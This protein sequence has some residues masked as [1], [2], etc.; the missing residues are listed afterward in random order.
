MGRGP[1][2]LAFLLSLVT[3]GPVFA[4]SITLE[5]DA[6]SGTISGYAVYVGSAQRIDVGNT[7]TFTLTTAAA[8]QQYCFAVA[9]YNS[10]G[11]GPKSG[12]VCGYSNQ[13]PALTN[14]GN[15]SATVGQSASLQLTGSDP[16]GHAITYSAAGLPP[17]LFIGTATGFVS[18]TP[19]AAGSYSVTARVHDGMLQSSAQTFTWSVANAP[20][21][22]TSSPLVTISGPTSSPTYTSSTATMSLNGSSSD[23]V[24]VTSVS[25]VNDRGGSGTASGTTSW[26]IASVGLQVGTNVITVTARDAAGNVG[27]DVLTVTHSLPDTTAPSVAISSPTAA[28]THASASST[29]TISGAAAD[30]VGVTQVSWANDRGGSGTAAGTTN[31]SASGIVL[32]TGANVI[33]VTARDAAANRSTDV[34][35]VTYTP[36]DTAAPTIT[37]VGPTTATS[38]S[39]TSNVVTIGGSSSDNMGVTAV[40]WSNNRGGSGFSSGTTS[41]S[42]PSVS[43]HGGSNVITVTA[44]DAAGNRGTDVLTVNYAAPDTT[45]PTIAITGPTSSVSYATTSSSLPISGT[46]T[47]NV[48]VTQVAWSND[49]GGSGTATGTGSWSVASIALQSGANVITV[50][51]QDAAGNMGTDVLT[52]NYT[53]SSS[54]AKVPTIAINGPTTSSSYTTKWSTLGISG[55]ASDNVGVTSVAWSNDRGGSGTA[56]G[57][58]SWSVPPIALRSGINVITVTA[59]DAVGNQASDVL[60]V[61]Y[62]TPAPEEL[63]LTGQIFSSGQWAKVLLQWK[64]PTSRGKA[65]DIYRDG[66][67]LTR[68]T[69]DGS[70]T[71]SVSGTGPFNYRICVAWT[72]VCSNVV[73][74]SK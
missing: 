55:R 53:A 10:V 23:S 4:D 39:T 34:L 47:D 3:V 11:E 19:T 32:Q 48:G 66:R 40:T 17:G 68:T 60:T 14:P 46:A 20:T 44:Q 29:M 73:T 38:Y 70:Y 65:I 45:V 41:W 57:T 74:L 8:G 22:D 9:A 42:V 71:D 43:L 16:E 59:R 27:T 31:W 26:G 72:S 54:D 25:W 18:G 50:A 49:R 15:Q 52:V 28:T 2:A 37:I 58:G 33:T 5:W 12:Q 21:A 1:I 64:W 35:T 67:K 51:V 7:T 13:F 61:N 24:G 56:I 63:A 62:A 6:S 69:N 30:A 36:P